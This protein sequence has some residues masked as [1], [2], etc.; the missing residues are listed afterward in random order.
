M[1]YLPL[2]SLFSNFLSL[3]LSLPSSSTCSYK[4]S[5]DDDDG[6]G[7][8]GEENTTALDGQP[9]PQEDDNREKIE[10]VCIWCAYMSLCEMSLVGD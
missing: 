4:E 7:E 9:V 5:T 10:K 1:Y 8:E 6:E 3:S 2:P